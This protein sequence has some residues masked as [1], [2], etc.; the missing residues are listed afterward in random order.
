MKRS[1]SL[2]YFTVLS[3]NCTSHFDLGTAMTAE[4]AYLSS[5]ITGSSDFKTYVSL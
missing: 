3:V 5:I 2:S 1:T 4:D